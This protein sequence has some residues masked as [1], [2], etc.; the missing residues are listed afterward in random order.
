MLQDSRETLK[1]NVSGLKRNSKD[2]ISGF[3]GNSKRQYF[4]IQRKDDPR[5]P[6]A[7]DFQF[8]LLVANTPQN[9]QRHDKGG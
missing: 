2:N 6:G 9:L 3:K 8:T 4:R 7:G 1:D 5:S